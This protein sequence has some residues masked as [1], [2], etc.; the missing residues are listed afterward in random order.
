M[1]G[2]KIGGGRILGSGKSLAPPAPP[3]SSSLVSP[4]ESTVS[5]PSSRDSTASP[6]G[7]SPL[8]ESREDL[9]SRVSLENG[10]GITAASSKL[11]CP[12]C[13]EEMV[14]L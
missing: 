7:T 8:P 9:I 13:A 3:R 1:S 11:V 12:I 6:L 2:R 5:L 4:S 10:G 14:G